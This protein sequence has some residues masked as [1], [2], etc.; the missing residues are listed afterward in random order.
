MRAVSFMPSPGDDGSATA[1]SRGLL[2]MSF[3]PAG[4]SAPESVNVLWKRFFTLSG[5]NDYVLSQVY[6]SGQ[7]DVSDIEHGSSVSAG[8]ERPVSLTSIVSPDISGFDLNVASSVSDAAM[9]YRV[10]SVPGY[11]DELAVKSGVGCFEGAS[12][13]GVLD[14]RYPGSGLVLGERCFAG[15]HGIGK[16]APAFA[17]RVGAVR[18]ECFADCSGLVTL[19]G[20]RM[21]DPV[22][23]GCFLR[24]I[25]L[26]SLKGGFS[27]AAS[28][29]GSR[30]FEGCTGLSSLE[31]LLVLP[32]LGRR[33]F[34]GCDGLTDLAGLPVSPADMSDSDSVSFGDQ[35]FWRCQGLQQI[36][37][38]DIEVARFGDECFCECGSLVSLS[39]LPKALEEMGTG[40]FSWCEKLVD[41][42]ALETLSVP[43]FRIPDMCFLGDSALRTTPSLAGRHVPVGNSA[44]RGCSSMPDLDWLDFSTLSVSDPAPFVDEHGVAKDY[45]P[46]PVQD[47]VG[48]YAFAE[49][50]SLTTAVGIRDAGAAFHRYPEGLFFGCSRLSAV[51]WPESITSIGGHAFDGCVS[52]AGFALPLGDGSDSD[53]CEL[54]VYEPVSNSFVFNSDPAMPVDVGEYAFHGCRKLRSIEGQVQDGWSWAIHQVALLEPEAVIGAVLHGVKEARE[55]MLRYDCGEPYVTFLSRFATMRNMVDY[56]VVPWM[57]QTAFDEFMIHHLT[58]PSAIF[59]SHVQ[60]N[61]IFGGSP[62]FLIGLAFSPRWMLGY[63][64]GRTKTPKVSV[65]VMPGLTAFISSDVGTGGQVATPMLKPTAGCPTPELGTELYSDCVE[66]RTSFLTKLGPPFCEA[67]SSGYVSSSESSYPYVLHVGIGGTIDMPTRSPPWPAMDCIVK[68]VALYFDVK[69]SIPFRVTVGDTTIIETREETKRLLLDQK[70]EFIPSPDFVQWG[71]DSDATFPVEEFIESMEKEIVKVGG[72]SKALA[73]W[74][75]GRSLLSLADGPNGIDDI[76]VGYSPEDEDE[77]A[78]KVCVRKAVRRAV[79]TAITRSPVAMRRFARESSYD[80]CSLLSFDG[81]GVYPMQDVPSRSFAGT[82]IKN[83]KFFCDAASIGRFAF[84][85]CS[86]LTSLSGWPEL[87]NV[88]PEGAF[89]RCTRLTSLHGMPDGMR[90]RRACFAG[91]GLYQL[92]CASSGDQLYLFSP[93]RTVDYYGRSTDGTGTAASPLARSL[94]LADDIASYADGFSLQL[95]PHRGNYSSTDLSSMTSA[96]AMGLASA[97]EGI[98]VFQDGPAPYMFADTAVTDGSFVKWVRAYYPASFSKMVRLAGAPVAASDVYVPVSEHV[99]RFDASGPC[100]IMVSQDGN[101]LTIVRPNDAGERWVAWLGGTE[102][103]Y[104]VGLPMSNDSI[105][106]RRIDGEWRFSGNDY[107][108]AINPSPSMVPDNGMAAGGGAFGNLSEF[109]DGG[110]R[111]GSS[112][113]HRSSLQSVAF[114]H[115]LDP[116]PYTTWANRSWLYAPEDVRTGSVVDAM[117][118]KLWDSLDGRF[119]LAPFYVADQNGPGNGAAVGADQVVI[120]HGFHYVTLDVVPIVELEIS[121]QSGVVTGLKGFSVEFRIAGLQRVWSGPDGAPPLSIEGRPGQQGTVVSSGGSAD[122]IS[123]GSDTDYIPVSTVHFPRFAPGMFAGC[124]G[125]SSLAWVPRHIH[126]LPSKC[127]AGTG[128]TMD[129]VPGWIDDVASDCFDS[130]YDH[131]YGFGAED[132]ETEEGGD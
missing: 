64:D 70:I 86:Q 47:D 48:T 18:R 50:T 14:I 109:L 121:Q 13:S 8:I 88:V 101:E 56:S 118:P 63:V 85:D 73:P 46:M 104:C 87:A 95:P 93:D 68:N 115:I 94:I 111:L 131:T 20:M 125:L 41:I 126:S 10:W 83:L 32:S 55:R 27:A 124:T 25:G 66:L 57:F 28:R 49:C 107:G 127:F 62:G 69:M 4:F 130:D 29:F 53:S 19:S 36:G 17:R 90:F 91:T 106:M 51:G 30:L 52:L 132:D 38:P 116:R 99:E 82:K 33:C 15:C 23:D 71:S 54:A 44:F 35:A 60:A 79:H 61:T 74:L 113:S 84:A 103:G 39:G 12:I 9:L 98:R 59:Y 129:D 43:S 34:A 75:L 21:F 128:L 24:C 31:G 96:V 123:D 1:V 105:T 89:L 114:G 37:A 45:D 26:S 65:D 58:L 16:I 97:L 120:L 122:V 110:G 77:D 102:A 72:L 2:S 6:F 80:G 40:C 3:V 7:I 76:T 112:T 78:R 108:V 22:A 67:P 11:V 92:D 5:S 100:G 117:F 119:S 81:D 42:S